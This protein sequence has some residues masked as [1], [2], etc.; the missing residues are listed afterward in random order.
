LEQIRKVGLAES[1][2]QQ[3]RRGTPIIGICGGFQMLGSRIEDPLYTESGK[4]SAEGLGLLDIVTVFESAK[5]TWQI[6]ARTV[7]NQ[8]LF[9]SL[10][11]M[12]VNGYEIHMAKC[13]GNH[14]IPAFRIIQRGDKS[15]DLFDGVADASG[16]I[17]GTYIHGLF[18]NADFRHA[19][20]NNVRRWK[21]LAPLSAKP[22]TTREEHYDKLADV[23]ST[24]LNM[25]LI[26]EI[27]DLR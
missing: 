16:R 3:V 24:S 12:E 13:I 11:D 2:V 18:D 14:A 10:D 23:V 9:E 8:G 25:A 7:Y 22:M 15:C 4:D 26:H 19:F 17:I 20:L 21:G 6:K 5:T 1:I 27:C